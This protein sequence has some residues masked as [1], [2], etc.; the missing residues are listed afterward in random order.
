MKVSTR[1]L[2]SFTVSTT[3]LLVVLLFWSLMA[4]SF[5]PLILPSPGE[6]WAALKEIS[7]SGALF[8]NLIITIRRTLIGYGSAILLGSLLA[9][10]FHY[11][12]ILRWFFRPLITVIQTIPPVIWLA[13]AVIWFGIAD[14]LT[15]V[16]LIF[17]VTM[18]VI[19]VNFF[20]GLDDI[21]YNLIE[22]AR[23]YKCSRYQVIFNIFLPALIPQLIAAINIGLAFAWKSTVFAEYLGS[24]KGIGFALSMANS[25]LETDR[26]FA[27]A[28]VLV[29]LMFTFDYLILKKVQRYVTR[30]NRNGK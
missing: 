18:P 12:K 16:F 17:M 22:M 6:T 20:S 9:I 13:L 25:N 4:R 7:I 26:L 19:F 14:D 5:N 15:P 3:G 27:W 30:W 24:S 21:D 10:L 23:V 2:F 29:A 8:S 28:I 1:N 11:S